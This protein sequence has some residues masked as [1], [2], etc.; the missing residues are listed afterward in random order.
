MYSQPVLGVC[1]SAGAAYHKAMLQ[2]TTTQS[3]EIFLR[4]LQGQNYSPKTLR[5]YGDDLAQFLAWVKQ[6]RVDWDNPLRFSRVDIEGFMQYLAAQHMSGVTRVRKLAAIRKF[7][8]FMEENNILAANPANTVK[9]ARREEKEP[10]ILYKEQY[11]ALLYEASDNLRD[12]AII[13]TFLQTGIRL[14]EL[15]NLR[16][17]DVDLEHRIL[18]VRQGKGKKDRQIP[19]VDGAVK[20]LRNY[21]RYRNTEIILDDDVFFLAKNGTSMNVSTIK[22]LVAKYVKKAGIRK[23]VSVHTLRHTFGAHK[24][25]KNMGIATLQQLMGHKKKETTLKYIHLAKT[26]LRQEMVQT[27]L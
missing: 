16:V 6:N 10:H 24:A 5:A 8:A 11:K 20:A 23:K 12:Y 3:L 17:D 7:F 19:L 25:D 21:A 18:T 9:G 1:H 13:Q 4:A 15:A 2:M 14:S 26:N 22:Y 27:A